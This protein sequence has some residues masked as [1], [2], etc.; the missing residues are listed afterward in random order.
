MFTP[1]VLLLLSV[2]FFLVVLVIALATALQKSKA[3]NKRLIIE[4]RIKEC[5]LI[6]DKT[7][8]T[9]EMGKMFSAQISSLSKEF[10]GMISS[11]PRKQISAS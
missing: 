4:H 3:E 6:L 2:V 10:L 11:D 1:F 5:N 7:E 9:L 8:R